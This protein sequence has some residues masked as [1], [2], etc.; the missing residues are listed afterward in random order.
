MID[1]GV[2]KIHVQIYL[3]L[4]ITSHD[5]P[6]HCREINTRNIAPSTH[7]ALSKNINTGGALKRPVITHRKRSL[8]IHIYVFMI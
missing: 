4:R 1:G 5:Y 8:L 7:Y 2:G 6:L 3:T